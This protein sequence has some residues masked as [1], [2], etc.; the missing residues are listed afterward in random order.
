MF[1]VKTNTTVKT[2]LT[3][4]AADPPLSRS[5]LE[6]AVWAWLTCGYRGGTARQRQAAGAERQNTANFDGTSYN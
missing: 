4:E 1:S 3:C 5:S 2:P 6:K